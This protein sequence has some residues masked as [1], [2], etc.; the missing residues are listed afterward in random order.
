MA[1]VRPSALPY[2]LTDKPRISGPAIQ[3]AKFF[4]GFFEDFAL[5]EGK[6]LACPVDVEI[7]Y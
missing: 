6:F 3:F 7:E 4:F 2:R 5:L 1:R